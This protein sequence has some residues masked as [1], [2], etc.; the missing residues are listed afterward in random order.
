MRTVVD[1][2]MDRDGMTCLEAKELISETRAM[3][4]E[5]PCSVDSIMADQLGL[6]PD[7]VMDVLMC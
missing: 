1:I 6:E 2:L 7:Y 3:L 5:N 4:I